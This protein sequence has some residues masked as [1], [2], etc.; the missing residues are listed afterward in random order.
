MNYD[1]ISLKLVDVLNLEYK[2]SPYKTLK[3]SDNSIKTKYLFYIK[4]Y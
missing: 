2:Y 4:L 3:G 1:T